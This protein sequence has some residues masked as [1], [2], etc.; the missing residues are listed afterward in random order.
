M[1]NLLIAPQ[2]ILRCIV[3]QLFVF[4]PQKESVGQPLI[5]INNINKLKITKNNVDTRT[6]P[7]SFPKRWITFSNSKQDV[8]CKFIRHMDVPY[9][10]VR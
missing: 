9:E 7:L 4:F 10:L 5:E 1:S 6:P 3:G 8:C 2:T